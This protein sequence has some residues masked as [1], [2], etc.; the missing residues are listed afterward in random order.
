[1]HELTGKI[2]IYT[3]AGP[4][5]S[6][7][8]SSTDPDDLFSDGQSGAGV[9]K[10]VLP[11]LILAGVVSA[12][13]V[14]WVQ[15]KNRLTESAPQNPE[16]VVVRVESP[17]DVS[18]PQEPGALPEP[19]VTGYL[20]REDAA[21]LQDVEHLGGFVLGDLA[22]PKFAA[23]LKKGDRK[24]LDTFFAP[25]FSGEL[26]D[27]ATGTETVFSF[28][29][30]RVWKEA[31]D[32]KNAYQREPFLERL[33][34]LRDEFSEIEKAKLKVI[35]MTPLTRG[36]FDGPWMGSCKLILAGR[37]QGGG[38]A[39]RITKFRCRITG[40]SS[41]TPERGGWL[42]GLE[43]ISDEY[44]QS[45]HYLMS[46][47]T[48]ATG[49]RVDRLLDNWTDSA[50]REKPYL[51]G[52]V[53]L[54]DYNRDGHSDV[55]LTDVRDGVSFYRGEGNAKFSEVTAILGP[56][57]DARTVIFADWDNDGDEDLLVDNR[58]FENLEGERFRERQ[59]GE[60]RLP[61]T[62]DFAGYAVA[63]YD[64]DGAL[65]LYA[66]GGAHGNGEEAM[67]WIGKSEVNRNQLLRNLGNWQFEDVTE[68]AGVFGN[69]SP[70]F[71]ACWFDAN[72]DN[73]PD[74]MTACYGMNDYFINQ[75]DGTFV[76]GELPGG[77]GGFSMGLSIDDID[78]DGFGDPYMGN[79]YSK[80]GERVMGNIRPGLYP[81]KVEMLMRDFV[82][83]NDLYRNEG[84]ATYERIGISSGINDVGWAYGVGYGDIN[85]DG[86]PDVYS[87]VGFQSVT[88]DKP[89]G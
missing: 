30:S 4:L 38:V 84:D 59:P 60:Y 42:A 67:K 55:L 75:G 65:D 31:D 53:Y 34:K 49:I 46:D 72:G 48:K 33:W 23:A 2:G 51:T 35:T 89:D 16:P 43:V 58:L 85:S 61:M 76:S 14:I 71:A 17:E 21:Y 50:G 1:M 40:I 25:D 18:P 88:A 15:K 80:A 87:P 13:A 5:Y 36:E 62:P 64:R 86:L 28:G 57:F 26:F 37:T 19:E 77:Y 39:K 27:A 45:E 9:W 79:M 29:N 54:C 73:W 82:T 66:V 12:I 32:A 11:M 6:L 69:G 44:A 52:G 8:M 68:E 24:T 63:D 22:F 78:N 56:R 47:I 20:S 74:V 10:G 70:T 7:S 81:P 41:D 3:L 83:G